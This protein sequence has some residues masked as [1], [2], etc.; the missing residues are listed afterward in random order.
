MIWTAGCQSA[1]QNEESAEQKGEQSEEQHEGDHGHENKQSVTLTRQQ[2]ASIDIATGPLEQ[3]TLQSEVEVTGELSLFP[4]DRARVSPYFGGNI[5][6]INVIEG[7]RVQKGEVI[8][9]L[10]HPDFIRMQRDL[11]QE[12]S[13][14]GYLKAEYERKK[15]LY[16]KDVTSGQ[17]FQRAKADYH[18]TRSSVKS[19]EAKLE[20]LGLDVEKVK[21][22]EIVSRIPVQAPI[23]GY[24]HHIHVSISDYAEPE[25][26]MFEITNNSRIHVDVR[27]FEKDVHL[28]EQGQ[29]VVFTVANR[30]GELLKAR[31]H[32]VGRA[33]ENESKSIHVHAHIDNNQ[34]DLMPGMYVEGRILTGQDTATVIPEEAV[35]NKEEKRYV[36]VE[37]SAKG[38]EQERTFAMKQV[39]TG[40]S[41]G[42]Y[43]EVRPVEPL[44]ADQQVVQKGAYYLASEMKQSE[45]G[46]HH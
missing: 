20:L 11:Q 19:L 5:T 34:G 29:K 15:R 44:S 37:T 46:G 24:I 35:V 28:L 41:F 8:A 3:K 12:A 32:S 17:K 7:D 31:V 21:E 10:Q 38:D 36:F 33:F 40:S 9:R 27:V 14:L 23:S 43:T 45:G 16:E 26:P 22:G 30:P 13:E 6:E 42:G 1:S 39:R 25:K 2:L 18:A 4:Q